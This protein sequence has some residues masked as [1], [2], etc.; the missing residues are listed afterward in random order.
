MAKILVTGAN[1]MLGSDLCEIFKEKGHQVIGTDL[2]NLDVCD[3]KTVQDTIIQIEPDFVIHLAGMTDV[4]DCEK[5]PEKAFHINTIGTQHVTLACQKTRALLVYLSTL[6]VFDG[7]KCEP[8]TEFDTPNPQSWYSRS[9]YRGELVVEKLLKQYYIVRAG[10][11]F[12][13][14]LEDKKFV[15][16]I[17]DLALKNGSIDVVDDKYGSPTYTRDISS[18]IER[19]IKTGLY[20]TYHMVNTGGYCSRFEY[21]QAIVKYAGIT[22]CAVHPVNSASFPLPAPRPRI[23]AACNYSLELHGWN[24]MPAWRNSLEGYIKTVLLPERETFARM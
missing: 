23:E 4:D 8:Y 17:M 9:K 12:G 2:E 7:T 19:L 3:F 14:G 15:A 13:G 21:A 1:G 5:D 24:W 20:G 11:M 18:G 22:T 6:S 16:K 10:W